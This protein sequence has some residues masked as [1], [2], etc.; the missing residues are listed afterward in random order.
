MDF[1]TFFLE[2]FL[3]WLQYLF[4]YC[5]PFPPKMLIGGYLSKFLYTSFCSFVIW[6]CRVGYLRF[7]ILLMQSHR[8]IIPLSSNIQCCDTFQMILIWFS[9][10]YINRK[11][12]FILVPFFLFEWFSYL[13]FIFSN[14]KFHKDISLEVIPL[15]CNYTLHGIFNLKAHVFLKVFMISF[16]V[17]VWIFS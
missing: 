15:K 17:I 1:S 13:F 2:I 10:L 14:V 8:G 6:F 16:Y 11:V 12:S 9:F 5:F 4:E 7:Q 3:F